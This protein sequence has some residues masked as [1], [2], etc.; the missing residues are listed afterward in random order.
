[1]DICI[2]DLNLDMIVGYEENEVPLKWLEGLYSHH[3]IFFIT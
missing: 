1:M 3:F 2:D